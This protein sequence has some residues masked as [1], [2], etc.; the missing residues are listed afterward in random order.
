MP[1]PLPLS[2]FAFAF[3]FV[4]V[5]VFA[6]VFAFSSAFAFVLVLCFYRPPPLLLYTT[7]VCRTSL[8]E[9]LSKVKTGTVDEWT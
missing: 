9:G 3:A 2:A 6:F 1:L 4:F 8:K 7:G 5:F